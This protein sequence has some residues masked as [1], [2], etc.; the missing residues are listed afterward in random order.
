MKTL[1]TEGFEHLSEWLLRGP[2]VRPRRFT[3]DSRQ[4][5]LYAF[6]IEDEIR[7]IAST[8]LTLHS[9]LSEYGYAVGGQEA[10]IQ[11]RIAKD[12]LSSLNIYIYGRHEPDELTRA[13]EEARLVQR[14]APIWN[15]TLY[16]GDDQH[17][18]SGPD[19]LR[20]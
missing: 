14:F 15:R 5:W 6:V 12:L 11:E 19:N 20:G 1:K 3:W 16:R 17:R 4:G 2:K 8:W 9:R 13:A 10:W 18:P 7:Y